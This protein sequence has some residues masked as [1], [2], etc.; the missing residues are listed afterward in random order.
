MNDTF[1]FGRFASYFRFDLSRLDPEACAA[2]W[3]T[4]DEEQMRAIGIFRDF[5][6]PKLGYTEITKKYNDAATGREQVARVRDCWPEFK[7]KLQAQLWSFEKMRKC[8][9]VVGAPTDPSD[10]GITRH[11]LHDMFEKVQL[12]RWRF[13][14]LDLAK[15]GRFYDELVNAIFLPGHAWDINEEQPFK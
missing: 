12:M 2:A 6:A 5:P 9:E 13:N 8:F 11:K 14:V 3:P 1:S 10:I 7:Q 4:I 15:R